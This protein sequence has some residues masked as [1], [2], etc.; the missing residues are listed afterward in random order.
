M[1]VIRISDQVNQF[2]IKHGKFGDSHDSVLRRL[3]QIS[4][5]AKE[6]PSW[7]SGPSQESSTTPTKTF[8]QAILKALVKSPS[9]QLQG[10]KVVDGVAQ[11]L[12]GRLTKGDLRKDLQGR[13][14]WKTNIHKVRSNLQ[15]EGL[16]QVV[17]VG[18]RKIWKLTP[19]GM[20]ESQKLRQ[21]EA[22]S[23]KLT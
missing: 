13:V 4:G 11:Q 12:K 8:R 16:L 5:G 17:Q 1:P 9:G 19:Q 6:E 3:L 14:A 21:Q 18:E 15:K 23:K 2:I 7:G 22:T 10:K 20:K